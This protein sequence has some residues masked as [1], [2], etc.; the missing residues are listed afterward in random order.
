[1]DGHPL[2]ELAHMLNWVGP[3]IVYSKHW[4]MEPP[5]ERCPLYSTCKRRLGDAIQGLTH[6]I[7]GQALV[8]WAFVAVFTRPLFLVGK[9]LAQRGSRSASVFVILVTARARAG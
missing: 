6:G 3:T 1:M 2:I 9:G 7:V 4:L 5:R 8:R